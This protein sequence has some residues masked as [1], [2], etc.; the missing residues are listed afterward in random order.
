LTIGGDVW[1]VDDVPPGSVVT[2]GDVRLRV[3]RHA[4]PALDDRLAR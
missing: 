1:L 2:P 4:P 3:L